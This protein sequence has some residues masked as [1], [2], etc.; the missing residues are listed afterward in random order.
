MSKQ[1]ES[2][3]TCSV[4]YDFQR[5]GGKYKWR[6][7]WYIH[8]H[9]VLRYGQLRKMVTS[10]TPKM[11]TQTLRELEVDKLVKRKVYFEVLPKVE[12]ILTE[13]AAI[14]SFCRAFKTMGRR[15]TEKQE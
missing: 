9:G 2:K 4:D 1:T 7:I 10:I 5:I 8:A 6:I 3:I 13:T 15:T 12:Y 11:L 14:N